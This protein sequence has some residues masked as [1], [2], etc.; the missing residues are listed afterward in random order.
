MP[1]EFLA[2]MGAGPH[3]RIIRDEEDIERVRVLQAAGLLDAAESEDKDEVIIYGL[4]ENGRE[5]LK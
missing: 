5:A 3:P 1:F 2:Q 4:T